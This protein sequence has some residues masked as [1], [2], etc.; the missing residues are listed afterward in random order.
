MLYSR[1]LLVIY[2]TSSSVYPSI[3]N[4]QSIPLPPTLH[5]VT[6]SLL[7]KSVTGF[8]SFHTDGIDYSLSKYILGFPS[9]SFIVT[10][11]SQAHGRMYLFAFLI[12]TIDLFTKS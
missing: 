7:S 6:I 5:P 8:L 3:P 12:N 1:S 9:A 10:S 4:S 11:A 2:F